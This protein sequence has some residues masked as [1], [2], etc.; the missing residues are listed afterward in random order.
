MYPRQVLQPTISIRIR[1]TASTAKCL[2]IWLDIDRGYMTTRWNP[3]PHLRNGLVV[4]KENR[5]RIWWISTDHDYCSQYYSM[6]LKFLNFFGFPISRWWLFEIIRKNATDSTFKIL[7]QERNHWM[8]NPLGAASETLTKCVYRPILSQFSS[9]NFWSFD[10]RAASNRPIFR[11]NEDN[12]IISF[13]LLL[14]K[15]ELNEKRMNENILMVGKVVSSMSLKK[16][17]WLNRLAQVDLTREARE[18]LSF[19]EVNMNAIIGISLAS[20]STRAVSPEIQQVG[21]Q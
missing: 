20:L 11:F 21:W 7:E 10:N 8:S 5:N 13:H 17:A 19:S 16:R 15:T 2:F 14:I 12:I 4:Y 18:I 9:N 1:V 6:I 3:F